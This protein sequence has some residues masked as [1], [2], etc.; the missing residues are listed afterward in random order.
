MVMR[1]VRTAATAEHNG[2]SAGSGCAV[3]AELTETPHGWIL[4]LH[5]DA[6]TAEALRTAGIGRP[7]PVPL[8]M[9]ISPNLVPGEPFDI[10]MVHIAVDDELPDSRSAD[11]DTS[12]DPAGD[13]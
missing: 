6:G 1:K 5:A 9:V 8:S 7:T 10:E 4:T 2:G 3:R 12:A 11:V 13:S